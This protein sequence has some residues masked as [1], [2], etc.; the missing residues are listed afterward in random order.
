MS[1]WQGHDNTVRGSRS[2]FYPVVMM[3]SGIG[4]KPAN[5]SRQLSPITGQAP[6]ILGIPR[7]GMSAFIRYSFQVLGGQLD[8]VW[9]KNWGHP[10]NK[11]LAM[12][13]VA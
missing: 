7:G 8:V 9:L 4:L 11:N 2:A 5:F 10:D 1:I 3:H 6:V 12:G 13:S